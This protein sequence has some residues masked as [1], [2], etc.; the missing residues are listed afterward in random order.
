RVELVERV[1]VIDDALIDA[2]QSREDL[3]ESR[4]PLVEEP[5]E[6]RIG[7]VDLLPQRLEAA[8]DVEQGQEARVGLRR[9]VQAGEAAR[10]QVEDVGGGEVPAG[11]VD[12]GF[13]ARPADVCERG[14]VRAAPQVGAEIDV[15][16]VV[17]D[18]VGAQLGHAELE[19][20]VRGVEVGEAGDRHAVGAGL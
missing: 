12:L 20:D 13:Q 1:E 15:A 2:G 5:A 6:L 11:R 4:R 14:Q 18:V 16:E 19:E 3:V 10:G 7:A 8:V 9:E 17:E